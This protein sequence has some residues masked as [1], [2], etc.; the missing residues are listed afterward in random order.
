MIVGFAYK[1]LKI[2]D[3]GE[4][5]ETSGMSSSVWILR[6]TL[7]ATSESGVHAARTRCRFSGMCGADQFNE[8]TRAESKCIRRNEG[9]RAVAP[10]HREQ[11]QC[12]D[13]EP[14]ES[15]SDITPPHDVIE[16]MATTI[17]TTIVTTIDEHGAQMATLEAATPSQASK[18]QRKQHRCQE[19]DLSYH[20]RH[21]KSIKRKEIK[22]LS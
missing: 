15:D 11:D 19:K 14:S 3:T 8:E 2:E 9:C 17:V 6:K 7:S 1:W 18:N 21:R 4:G 22:L 5:A 10:A 12:T 20:N 16:E 13:A